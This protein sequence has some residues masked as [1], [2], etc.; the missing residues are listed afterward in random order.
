MEET[1]LLIPSEFRGDYRST[2]VIMWVT[3][4]PDMGRMV[5]ELRCPNMRAACLDYC[6]AALACLTLA[7]A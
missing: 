2:V 6:L 3:H 5:I 4:H 7:V 1:L